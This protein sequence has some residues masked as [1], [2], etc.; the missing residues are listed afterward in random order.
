M[1]NIMI[2][3]VGLMAAL[4]WPL[5]EQPALATP[6]LLAAGRGYRLLDDGALAE[7]PS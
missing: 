3:L 6:L 2:V 4:A 5:L 1:R 7:D